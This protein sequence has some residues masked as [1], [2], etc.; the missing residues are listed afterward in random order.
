[1][2]SIVLIGTG[3]V[4]KHLFDAFSQS[5]RVKIAQVV[6]RNRAALKQ[7][8]NATADLGSI[9]TA[10]AYIIAVSD[11]SIT[12]VSQSLIDKKGVVIHTSGSVAMKALYPNKDTGVFYPLQTFSKEREVDFKSI[13]ICIESNTESSLNL[14][15]GLGKAIS[16]KVYKISSE[17]REI[18]HLAAVFANNFTNHMYHIANEICEEHQVPFDIL[19]PLIQETAQKI[20]DHRP[21]AMQ[22]GPARRHDVDTIKKHLDQLRD[23]KQKEIY[24]L[25]SESISNKYGEKL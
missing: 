20:Q 12:A 2:I 3:N 10:D 19:N 4:A 18:L 24:A 1:M 6:G 13:P 14:L 11:D 8:G 17:Q 9:A 25:L 5:D 7:F 21:C 23:G 22:T 15:E 16:E